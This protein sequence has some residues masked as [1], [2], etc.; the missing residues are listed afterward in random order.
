MLADDQC[1]GIK[2]H[3]DKTVWDAIFDRL[4]SQAGD[5][6]RKPEFLHG[7][8]KE[9]IQQVDENVGVLAQL[10]AGGSVKRE[11]DQGVGSLG[12]SLYV[13][14]LIHPLPMAPAGA[15]PSACAKT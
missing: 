5:D 8:F 3:A 1:L 7:W 4:R 11:Y 2:P 10:V 15:E 9:Q 14:P 13:S 6:F 12:E